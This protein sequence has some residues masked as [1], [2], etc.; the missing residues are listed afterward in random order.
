MVSYSN[1]AKSELLGVDPA[2]IEAHGAVSEPVA[3]AMADGALHRFGA[4]TAVAITGI[5]G[6]AAAPPRSR[7]ARSLLREAADGTTDVR[8]MRLPAIGP[9]FANARRRSRCTCC[10]ARWGDSDNVLGDTGGLSHDCIRRAR[11]VSELAVAAGWHR[12]GEDR[13]DYS[14]HP[15]PHPRDLA[16]Q[17]RD[18]WGLAVPRRP[19]DG[20]H[21]RLGD[22]DGLAEALIKLISS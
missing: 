22:R 21:Q 20:L 13:T 7:W 2:L 4:D 3:E 18:Q 14:T 5:A 6:P 9:M 16:G 8:T 12:R 1:E 15:G 19:P 11:G 17:R 10:V